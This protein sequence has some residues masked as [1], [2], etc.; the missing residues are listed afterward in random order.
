[1]NTGPVLPDSP[2]T[3]FPPIQWLIRSTVIGLLHPG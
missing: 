3:T 2:G 1:L